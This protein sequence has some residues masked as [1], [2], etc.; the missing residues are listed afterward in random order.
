[1]RDGPVQPEE[2]VRF[3]A[4]GSSFKAK[5]LLKALRDAAA[6]PRKR[7]ETAERQAAVRLMR[8]TTPVSRLVCRHTRELLRRYHSTGKLAMRIADRDV[9]DVF[10]DLTPDAERPLY[11]A[12]EDY[13][14]STYNRADPDRKTAVGFV[15]TIY[16]RRLASSFYALRCTLE[17]RLGRVTHADDEDALDDETA[18]DLMDA[19]EAA[20]AK[21]QALVAEETAQI[22]TL[23]ERIRQLPIDSK[24]ERLKQV[25]A[26]LRADGYSQVIIFTQYTDTMDFLRGELK[27]EF[28]TRMICFSGRGGEV[29]ASDGSWSTVSRDTV[30]KRFRDEL[31]DCLICTDAAAEGLNFQFCG[32]LVNYDMPWNPMRVEQ[33]IGRIDRLGQKHERI[34][35]VNLHYQDTVEAD[36]YASLRHRIDL[37]KTFVGKLQPILSALPGKIAEAALTA[38]DRE[39]VR[40]NLATQVENEA[41]TAEAS[42]FDLD[43]I[44]ASDLEEPLRPPPL[45]DLEDLGRMLMRPDLLPPGLDVRPLHGSNRQ[46]S[47]SQPGIIEPIRIT[48]NSGFYEEHPESVELWSP[49]SPTFQAPDAM[50]APHDLVSNLRCARLVLPT[51]AI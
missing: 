30:K 46:F 33:R 48:T 35:I 12:V 10:I 15:M 27:G 44:A 43:E 29:L 38:G 37:F 28:G 24:A 22:D 26:G 21:M 49:G 41:A 19:D 18:D 5:K 14:S 17:D 25:L 47:F 16:R 42:G 39:Q 34:R 31:A 6:T 8:G 7:L 50:A 40:R 4:N 51:P 32:A 36:V 13:I 1:M 3:L 2:A 45:Y 23:L 20:D 9:K 11:T